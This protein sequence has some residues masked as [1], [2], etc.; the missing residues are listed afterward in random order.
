MSAP[1]ATST[2][3]V[4][5]ACGSIL[6][7]GPTFDVRTGRLVHVD[8][9]G[10]AVLSTPASPAA[11]DA[12]PPRV[13]AVLPDEDVGCI[14]LTPDPNVVLAALSRTVV[15]VRF[16]P[17]TTPASTPVAA[18]IGPALATLDESEG[19]KD[20]RFND[21]KVS[22]KGAFI[23]GRLHAKWRDGHTGAVYRL[24]LEHGTFVRVLTGEQW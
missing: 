2:A 3:V 23:I 13:E 21:G 10:R 22:P 14:A 18:T 16:H 6:G 11:P 8:I 24:D 1:P 19:V 12:S 20:M 7:E 9:S 17:P 15:G 5:H 4:V